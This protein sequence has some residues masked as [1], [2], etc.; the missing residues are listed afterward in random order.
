MI[1][2]LIRHAIAVEAGLFEGD[3]SQRPLTSKG[4]RKMRSIAHGLKEL[5]IQ[6]DLILTSPYLRSTQTAHILAKKFDLK[7]EQVILTD[8]LAPT[9]YAD[10]LVDEINEKYGDLQHIAIIGH[11]PYLSNLASLLITGDPNVSIV[12]KKGGICRLSIEKIQYGRCAILEWLL[13][14]SQLVE[15]GE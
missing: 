11:E 12:L 15:I 7:K 5:Q 3:E 4:R 10:Q 13:S 9:S 1:L 2:Y 6:L 8:H 14:P